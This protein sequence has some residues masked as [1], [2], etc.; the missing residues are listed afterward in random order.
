MTAS[1]DPIANGSGTFA[2]LATD[3]R[4]TLRAMLDK[5][6]Q[7]STGEVMGAFKVDVIG[8][9]SPL[10]TGV[11]TDVEYGVGPVA[12][13]GALAPGVGLLVAS[14]WRRSRTTSGCRAWS[15]R[16]TRSRARR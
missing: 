12:A 3:Q 16:P 1:L 10:A 14:E 9:L 2:I 7:P 11:L 15:R 13:A 8:A 6:G 4:G 5:A